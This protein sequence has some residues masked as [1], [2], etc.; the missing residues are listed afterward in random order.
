[1]LAAGSLRDGKE[2]ERIYGKM[3]RFLGLSLDLI[4]RNEGRISAV[5]FGRNL[6]KDQGRM[7]GL[8]DATVTVVDP[9]PDRDSFEGPDPTL[10]G[11]DRVFTAGINAH[12]RS[13]LGLETERD[14]HLLSKEV[15]RAWKIDLEKHALESQ[16][17]ATDDLRYGMVL[18]PFMK[19]FLTHGIYDMVTPYFSANRIIANMKLEPSIAA[20]LEVRHFKGG[21]M[22]YVW[23]ES[24]QAFHSA[25]RDFYREATAK[26][27]S[28]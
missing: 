1:L 4:R 10:Y 23:D 25:M 12:L 7:L 8:Y 9:F 21:H 28:G 19:V 13:N 22:F 26:D 20:N 15:N 6:L 2:R 16:I 11:I 27:R 3:V 14:Y 18:N 17:G 5:T 24:R